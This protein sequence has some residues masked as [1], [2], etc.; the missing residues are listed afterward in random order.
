MSSSGVLDWYRRLQMELNSMSTMLCGRA[1]SHMP[2]SASNRRFFRRARTMSPYSFASWPRAASRADL[3]GFALQR[4]TALCHLRD[5]R[6]RVHG[7]GEYRIAGLL[8]I[9]HLLVRLQCDAQL[10]VADGFL[11]GFGDDVFQHV[12][13]HVLAVALL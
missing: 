12:A 11:G 8:V 7:H 9:L 10:V 2:S 6:Q 13:L 4:H 3:D 5:G 1:K